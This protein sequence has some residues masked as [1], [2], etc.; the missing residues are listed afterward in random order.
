MSA[1]GWPFAQCQSMTL[2]SQLAAGIRMLDIR[3]SVVNSVLIAYHGWISQRVSFQE[4]L[5]TLYAFLTTPASLLE[6]IVMSIKQEDYETVS[7]L[8][9]SRLLRAEISKAPGGTG[10]WFLE[11]RIPKLGEARGKI[12]MLSRFDGEGPEWE[13]GSGIHPEL[14]PDSR[15][16][17]FLWWCKDT[18]VKTH[19]W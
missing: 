13:N 2:A 1:F 12:V 5:A 10:M 14:W 7:P 19:D 9:F 11:N 15:R 16:D 6:T 18:R 8:L 3:L 4:I 17:G